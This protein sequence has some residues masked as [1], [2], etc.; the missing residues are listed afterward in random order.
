[1]TITTAT[2]VSARANGT[3]L[4][5]FRNRPSAAIIDKSQQEK[6]FKTFDGGVTDEAIMDTVVAHEETAFIHKVNF[7]STRIAIFHHLVTSG[8]TLYDSGEKEYGFLQGIGKGSTFPMTPEVEVL[9]KV[10]K[11]TETPVPAIANVLAAKTVEEVDNLVDSATVKFKPRNFV[12]VPPF[13][14]ETI[15]DVVESK[16]GNTKLALLQVVTK[17]KEFDSDHASDDMYKDKAKTKCRDFVYW[18]YLASQNND[19][20]A[21]VNTIACSN[22]KLQHQL[23]A[24][25]AAITPPTTEDHTGSILTSVEASLKRPFE[26]LAATSSS[27]A[28]FME[29]LTQ[30]QS[31]AGEKAT[32][33]FKKIPAKYQQM[34]LVAASCSE[35]TEVDYDAPAVEFFK[36]STPLHAQVM[37]NSLFEAE[38]IECSV[39]PA[40]ATTLLYGSFLWKNAMSP[41]GLAASVLTSEGLLRN[42]T[43]QEGMV[44]DFATKFEVSA[45]SLSK[46]TKTQVLF[47]VDVDELTHRIRGLH[48]LTTF[49]FKSNGFLSQGI[50][51]VKN[52]CLD[53]RE[54]LKT[55]IYLDSKFIA[56]FLCAV[57]ERVYWWLK[58]CST[59]QSVMDTDL[60]LINYS[61]L[62]QDVKFNRFT[63]A[64]PPTI[65]SLVGN[66]AKEKKKGQDRNGN[67]KD[68]SGTSDLVK[69]PNRI[70]EWKLR[71]GE[72]WNNIF[73]N[74][75]IEGPMLQAQ[76]HPCL[77]FHVRGSCYAD[78]RNRASHRELDGEDKSRTD[79]FIKS[80]RGE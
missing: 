46:L 12:P 50:K 27:T 13:L 66:D 37:L 67:A 23:N 30:L 49:F 17:I 40:L 47:P 2:T 7:G 48:A 9:K 8:G 59:H 69:N 42:D 68:Q 62:I 35:I 65:A 10:E 80:L 19:A 57:D 54:I 43:L 34:I 78:C 71:H 60:S 33:T 36:C 24:L 14:L 26:V 15:H 45:A 72:S 6:L 63:Y 73:R 21:S 76:C 61:T 20:I 11:N 38:G 5:W 53:H 64:L 58:Q 28:D 29:K 79:L 44:L 41:S 77:K 32:K 52:F 3:W 1:M 16:H 56:K 22:T 39:S 70:E 31:T 55:K 75:T 51:Q 18:L 74:K 4:Q 25:E